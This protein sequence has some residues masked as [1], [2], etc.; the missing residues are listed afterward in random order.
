MT[1]LD[2]FLSPKLGLEA[3]AVRRL[4]SGDIPED[5][6]ERENMIEGIS[7]RLAA[8]H[9]SH[10]QARK[11]VL[12]YSRR[13]TQ[14]ALF[15]RNFGLEEDG[16]LMNLSSAR[17]ESSLRTL[18]AGH[19]ISLMS[20][21]GGSDSLFG[22]KPVFSTDSEDWEEIAKQLIAGAKLIVVLAGRLSPGLLVEIELIRALGK[23]HRT[24]IAVTDQGAPTFPLLRPPVHDELI[25]R[26]DL[27]DFFKDFSNVFDLNPQHQQE[28][29]EGRFSSWQGASVVQGL[30]ADTFSTDVD[31]T[32]AIAAHCG[33]VPSEIRTSADYATSVAVL[34]RGLDLLEE[35]LNLHQVEL[36]GMVQERPTWS[37]ITDQGMY[38]WVGGHFCYGLSVAVEDYRSMISSLRYLAR[39]HTYK[40]RD[41]D[42]GGLHL[43]IAR[44][45]AAL[46]DLKDEI[47]WLSEEHAKHA[48]LFWTMSENAPIKQMFQKGVE[49]GKK[50]VERSDPLPE[51]VRGQFERARNLIESARLDDAR[52]VIEDLVERCRSSFGE[53]HAATLQA[54]ELF[55]DLMAAE[56]IPPGA[57]AM[58]SHVLERL[59]A[60]SEVDR[61]RVQRKLAALE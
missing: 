45:I 7:Q 25:T 6:R 34:R 5:R 46:V 15:L 23:Q 52:P 51:A 61:Q 59:P 24:V 41:P 54:V 3:D 39:F 58:Y 17:F 13:R 37:E 36:V 56:V 19:G 32:K 42:S 18:V 31:V 9:H 26:G 21:R 57:I 40:L 48:A 11:I 2:V 60:G 14:L 44:N 43:M 8:I 53:E 30:A 33:Y 49:S 27:G 55:G 22:P 35:Q 10:F 1:N 28:D 20:L 4:L 38:G 16:G 47:M 29:E 50:S 12:D